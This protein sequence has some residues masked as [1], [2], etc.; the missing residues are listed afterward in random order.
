MFC[1]LADL[2]VATIKVGQEVSL[3]TLTGGDAALSYY[4]KIEFDSHRVT[5]RILLDGETDMPLEERKYYQ[6]IVE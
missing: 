2:N 4:V 6:V 3:L 1:D 5:S